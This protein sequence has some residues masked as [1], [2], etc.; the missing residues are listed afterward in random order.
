[1][2]EQRSVLII[3]EFAAESRYIK[4]I[5]P[6]Q[7]QAFQLQA[8]PAQIPITFEEIILSQSW[9][10]NFQ[11]NRFD[12][13]IISLT[14]DVTSEFLE[15]N[16]LL[17][18]NIRN[19]LFIHDH[20]AVLPQSWTPRVNQDDTLIRPFS[21]S[22]F[23]LR[24]EQLLFAQHRVQLNE[25]NDQT[26][27]DCL[28]SLLEKGIDRIEPVAN[29]QEH[30]GH[31]YPLIAQHFGLHLSAQDVLDHMTG[32][33]LL[34]KKL[35]NRM[36]VCN[37]CD[38]YNL[39]FRE[40]CPTC[41]SL[42]FTNKSLIKHL[43]CGHNGP[44]TTFRNGSE[45]ICPACSTQLFEPGVDFIEPEDVFHCSNCDSLFDDPNIEVQCLHCHHSCAP[46]ETNELF[47]YSYDILP[48]AHDAV[49]SQ[50]LVGLQLDTILRNQDTGI[51]SQSY[52]LHE[53]KREYARFQRYHTPVS[54]IYVRI[55]NLEQIKAQYPEHANMYVRNIFVAITSFLRTLDI[56]AIWNRETLAVLLPATDLL[57]A[58]AVEQRMRDSIA[59]LDH[60]FPRDHEDITTCAAAADPRNEGVDDI[61][62]AAEYGLRENIKG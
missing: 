16:S 13:A 56:T 43:A 60:P 22:S 25:I 4:T 24:T 19:I 21:E 47:V 49:H 50:N 35:F 54:M 46:S 44:S 27:L 2:T 61:L 55:N 36:R 51:Y 14:G 57:G 41:K 30:Q 29:Q 8:G 5:L 26:I 42:D 40:V 10:I 58:Q 1:M 45:L 28:D 20:G 6:A 15:K 32:L 11:A 12:L 7:L 52:F 23:R 53:I 34:H 3:C 9:G 17:R 48:I 62:Q 18:E 38:A 59:M 33:G 37:V 39:A 31:Y